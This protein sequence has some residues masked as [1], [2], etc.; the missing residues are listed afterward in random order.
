MAYAEVIRDVIVKGM[1]SDSKIPIIEWDKGTG[2]FRFKMG[3][4]LK[5][6]K[7]GKD[8]WRQ[9]LHS[10]IS[11]GILRRDGDW[12]YIPSETLRSFEAKYMKGYISTILLQ[13]QIPN[14]KRIEVLSI[15]FD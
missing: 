11:K 10:A 14:R 13:V 15:D 7:Q 6:Y 2:R 12:L 3:M 9:S 5:T 8:K 4:D 1:E